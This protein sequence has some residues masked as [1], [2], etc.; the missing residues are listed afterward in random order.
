MSEIFSQKRKILSRYERQKA[1]VAA[2]RS[3]RNPERK[4]FK[5][6][7]SKLLALEIR[8]GIP[9]SGEFSS[10]VSIDE[11]LEQKIAAVISLRRRSC[12]AD[13]ED[14]VR[15]KHVD[16]LFALYGVRRTGKTTMLLQSIADIPAEE[17]KKCAYILADADDTFASLAIDLLNLQRLG[18]KYIFIDEATALGNFP[19]ESSKFA[20]IHARDG[21]TIVLSGTDSLKIKLAMRSG[22][23]GRIIETHTTR[24]LFSE[25]HAIQGKSLKKYIHSGGI[26]SG[27]NSERDPSP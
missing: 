23:L 22:L 27:K 9:C 4:K 25:W 7:I 13:L 21:L 8:L 17:R 1:L 3:E 24:M 12:I 5:E 19:D 11:D 2:L 18:K 6:E 10:A 26:L 16:T 14:F 20:D 15:E